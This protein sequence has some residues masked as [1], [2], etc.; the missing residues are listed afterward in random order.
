MGKEKKEHGWRH[1]SQGEIC[2]SCFD[3]NSLATMLREQQQQ[4]FASAQTHSCF[5]SL[6]QV[7]HSNH[8]RPTLQIKDVQVFSFLFLLFFRP[9]SSGA[10]ETPK[11]MELGNAQFPSTVRYIVAIF[12]SGCWVCVGLVHWQ[13]SLACLKCFVVCVCVCVLGFFFSLRK[14]V[15]LCFLIC[16]HGFCVQRGV[17]CRWSGAA[18]QCSL[19]ST[20]CRC[21][22]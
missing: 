8:H 16:D 6:L 19:L 9:S 5:F 7:A 3:F 21:S 2:S 14:W 4:S 1:C 17:I 11:I 12:C 13:S 18:G 10:S 15:V 22:G 20:M